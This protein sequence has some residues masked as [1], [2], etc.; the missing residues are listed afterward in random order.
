[1]GKSIASGDFDADGDPDM[2]TGFWQYSNGQSSEGAIQVYLNGVNGRALAVQGFSVAINN[3]VDQWG[4]SD[5]PDG[6]TVAAYATSP[7][8]RERARL[9]IESCPV[10]R[11]F[12][13]IDCVLAS[14]ANWTDIPITAF[15]VDVSADI[16][17]L[18]FDSLQHWRARLQYAPLSSGTNGS[19][20]PLG[21]RSGPWRRMNAE[22]ILG[23]VRITD[24]L[25]GNGFE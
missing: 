19:L 24:S 7:F 4:K 20:R 23:D 8:G 1:M 2:A 22:P 21:P 3:P 15:P 25:F 17:G 16:G 6:F 5:D 11:P 12:G 10:A 13:H 14:G 18:A 9:Q